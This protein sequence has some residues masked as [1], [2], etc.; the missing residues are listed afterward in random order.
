[1]HE[2]NREY[3]F[4]PFKVTEVKFRG[5]TCPRPRSGH[6]IVCDDVNVYLFGGYNPSLPFNV[7]LESPTWSPSSPLFK[8]LWT[9]S[10]ARKRWRL[11]NLMENIPD[12]LASNALCMNGKYLLVYGGTGAPFGNKCNNDVLV[13]RTNS[14]EE[15]IEPI[16]VTGPR[17]PAQYGQA[18]FCYDGGFYTVGGTNGYSYNCDIYRLDLRTKMWGAEFIA[19]GQDG[20]PLGRYRHELARVDDKLFV[21]GGGTGEWAFELMEIPMFN[22]TTK[23]WTTLIPKPDDSARDIIMPL[24]RKCHSAVQISTPNGPQVYVAGG[25]DGQAVFEDVWRLNLADLQWTLMKKTVLPRPLYFHSSAVTPEGCMYVFG[26]IE[27]RDDAT[28]RNNILYK[29]WLCIPSLTEICWEALLNYHP[30]LEG[31]S[32]Q[33]LLAIGIPSHLVNRLHPIARY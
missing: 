14:T 29:V 33:R 3:V 19:T 20:E 9:F 1:M 28:C 10:I 12:E 22:L 27:P 13:W 5:R 32:R 16:H 2:Y 25:T 7:E 15:R 26:G 8:E 30:N 6:R 18:V 21:L 31:L 23:T 24:P 11:H 17:P 4:K